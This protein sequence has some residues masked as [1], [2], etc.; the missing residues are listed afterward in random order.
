MCCFYLRL[1]RYSLFD[2][3]LGA[4]KLELM[5]QCTDDVYFQ[6]NDSIKPIDF[7]KPSSPE[8]KIKYKSTE[9]KVVK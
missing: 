3:F 2:C 1:F 6:I 9:G 8:I 5:V 7:A 4:I